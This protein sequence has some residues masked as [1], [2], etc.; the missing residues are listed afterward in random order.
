MLIIENEQLKNITNYRVG[1]IIPKLYI[2]ESIL[3]IGLIDKK[4]LEESYIIGGGMNVLANDKGIKKPV[5]KIDIKLASIEDN[6]LTIGA[7][8]TINSA[9]LRLALLGFKCFHNLAGIPGTIGGGLTMNAG[10]SKSNISD[11]LLSVKCYNRKKGEIEILKKGDCV[12]GFRESIFK[13]IDDLIILSADFNLV[14]TDKQELIDLYNKINKDR[15]EKFPCFFSSVGCIFKKPYGGK[16]IIEK[17]GMS[18][19]IKGGAIVSPLFPAF[20]LN[21]NG[22]TFEDIMG[23]IKE[24]QEK[25]KKIGEEM[26]LEVVVWE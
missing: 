19:K 14:K 26:P 9:S 15:R 24:I 6:I 10:A 5:L 17:I 18:G 11:N 25:A 22:A 21:Y 2:I 1:G 7:G 3:D 16:D 23:L 20:I 13:K 12:F 8:D 4:D